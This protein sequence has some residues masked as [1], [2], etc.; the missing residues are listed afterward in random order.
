MADMK[1]K[2]GFETIQDVQERLEKETIAAEKE[3]IEEQLN[4]EALGL[5]LE[6]PAVLAEKRK[7]QQAKQRKMEER[8]AKAREEAMVQQR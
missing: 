8:L 5:N 4:D 3:E 1:L 6:D 2:G 7:K